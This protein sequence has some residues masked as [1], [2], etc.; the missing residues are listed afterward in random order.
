MA[1]FSIAFTGQVADYDPSVAVGEITL[2]EHG[3][4]FHAEVGFWQISDYESSWASALARVTS[5]SVITSCL[6]TSISNPEHANFIAVWPMYRFGDTIHVQ[7]Q[8]V[9]LD[10]LTEPFDPARPWDYVDDFEVVDEDGN[11]ISDWVVSV[12]EVVDFMNAGLKE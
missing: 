8:M 7:N 4:T 12:S 5:E 3:E 10:E 9:F 6:V 1:S 2:G 11:D